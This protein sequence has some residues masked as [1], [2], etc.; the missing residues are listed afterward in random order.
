M[1]I[2]ILN[3]THAGVRRDM[4]EMTKYQGR[5]YEEVF[6]P[7]LDEHD[8]KHII[9][10]GDYF[11]RRKFV[12]FATLKSNREHFIDPM[13]ER[14]I[15]MDL[16]I[17]NHDVYYKNT[18]DVNAPELLLFESDNINIIQEPMVKEYDGVN[19]A[20]VPWINPENYADSV[21]FLTTANADTCM[22][23]FEFEGALMMPGMTCQHGLDHSYVKRFDK[24][25][26][27]HFHQ[28][29]EFANIKYL[30]SQMQFTWSDY[31]DEKYFHIFDTD[32]REMRPIHNPITMFEK[33][34]Y[35]DTK[36]SFET[37]SNKDYTKYKGKFTKVIVVNKDNPYWFDSMLDKLHEASP[38]HV[39]VV[40]DHKHM[41]LMDDSDIEG[42]EDTLT[43][44]EKYIDG[45]EI[46]GQKK[47]LLDLMTSLYNE[48]LDEHNYI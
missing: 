45:L 40:D 36:E 39:S 32:T 38:L 43:I 44:L 28:K 24:V 31:G 26:S 2:A 1:K 11:D 5:F 46:Q 21:E 17:G 9:H 7:Y 37:I 35:D 13:L 41:D 34:F 12:N 29:S 48:A 27:G 42:V 15:T 10:L 22:G 33:L 6:F 4:V 18:N 30:G 14:G 19:L 20:L 8:I 25:Y 47:P 3:D 16:I 23:H